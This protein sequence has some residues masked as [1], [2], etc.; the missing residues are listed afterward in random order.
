M[1]HKP[2]KVLTNLI[3]FNKKEEHQ[4]WCSVGSMQMGCESGGM[5]NIIGTG[6]LQ[7]C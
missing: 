7:L 6:I 2:S 3:E 5:G 4:N 1:E